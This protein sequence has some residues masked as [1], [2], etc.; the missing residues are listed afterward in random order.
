VCTAHVRFC[1]QRGHHAI[2]R[3]GSPSKR[4]RGSIGGHHAATCFDCH[5]I[6]ARQFH[7]LGTKPIRELRKVLS[8]KILCTAPYLGEP[9]HAGMYL[10]VPDKKR[11]EKPQNISLFRFWP[12]ADLSRCTAYVRFRGRSGHC[13]PRRPRSRTFRP[14][15]S[16][17]VRIRVAA[18]RADRWTVGLDRVRL[19]F[20]GTFRV[21][22]LKC[23]L[24]GKARSR[25]CK[26]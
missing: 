4:S 1:G 12:K 10:Q 21:R 2:Q 16:V 25:N 24:S 26:Q 15:Y 19:R 22:L 18:M 5:Y 20:H 8:G 13:D 23:P 17:G 6:S 7:N 9:V 11:E 3:S 14:V